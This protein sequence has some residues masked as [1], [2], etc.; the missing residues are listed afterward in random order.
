[1]P[2]VSMSAEVAPVRIASQTYDARASTVA[3]L[4][5]VLDTL[6]D[7]VQ[8]DRPLMDLEIADALLTDASNL[9]GRDGPITRNPMAASFYADDE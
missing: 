4:L 2:I 6:R 9:L 8:R 7:Y 5:A 3:H 1:M